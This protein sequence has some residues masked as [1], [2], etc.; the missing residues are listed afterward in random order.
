MSIILK[1]SLFA[2]CVIPTVIA[3]LLLCDSKIYS[4]IDGSRDLALHLRMVVV[5]IVL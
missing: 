3:G 2:K 5:E 1:Y 4:Y